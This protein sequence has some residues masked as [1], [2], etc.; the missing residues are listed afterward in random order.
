MNKIA[1]NFVNRSS[2]GIGKTR[3][4]VT[5]I[6]HGARTR[7]GGAADLRQLHW[8][9]HLIGGSVLAAR[10]LT[11]KETDA[12]RRNEETRDGHPRPQAS[13]EM[14]KYDKGYEQTCWRAGEV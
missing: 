10:V 13:L 4:R 5:I 7:A 3:G 12:E 9:Y 11:T 6:L 2:S 1:Q 14:K 8:E